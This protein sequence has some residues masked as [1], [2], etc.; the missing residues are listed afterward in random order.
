MY[1]RFQRAQ[2]YKK[3]VI[4]P[5]GVSTMA[6]NCLKPVTRTFPFFSGTNSFSD[7]YVF[8]RRTEYFVPN[9]SS[10]SKKRLNPIRLN[11]LECNTSGIQINRIF[12]I[13]IL[14][15]LYGRVSTIKKR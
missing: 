14:A 1:N 4:K 12:N 9:S 15:T 3:G 2:K 5:F 13:D 10:T 7:S 6:T 11:T 8:E